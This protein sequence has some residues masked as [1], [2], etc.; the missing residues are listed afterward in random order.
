MA[1]FLDSGFKVF[2]LTP[3]GAHKAELKPASNS[4]AEIQERELDA[5][6]TEPTPI[7]LGAETFT[8]ELAVLGA[9]TSPTDSWNM[10]AIVPWPDVRESNSI[11]SFDSARQVV[12]SLKSLPEDMSSWLKLKIYPDRVL[13]VEMPLPDGQIGTIPID[14]GGGGVSIPPAQYQAWRAAHPEVK[15]AT[16]SYFTIGEGK[17]MDEYVLADEVHI[18]ALTV[19]NV[20][21]SP[22]TDYTRSLSENQIG[23]VGMD[24]LYYVDMIVD[25]KEGYAYF[26]PHRP[27]DP[28]VHLPLNWRVDDSV[29]VGMD[30]ILLGEAELKAVAHDYAGANADFARALALNPTNREAYFGRAEMER[31]MGEQTLAIADYTRAIDLNL[32]WIRTARPAMALR[33]RGVSRQIVGDFTGAVADYDMAIFKEPIDA[34]LVSI[35]RQLLQRR[36]GLPPEDFGKTVATWSDPWDKAMG[37]YASGDLSETAFLKTLAEAPDKSNPNQACEAYYLVGMMHLLNGDSAGARE[38]F[39][40]SMAAGPKEA[41]EYYM[42]QSEL[43]RLEPS[44]AK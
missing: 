26:R 15:P 13:V 1:I 4:A 37:Q 6:L 16:S 32:D 28:A 14:T 12:S 36:L 24:A 7:K 2:M 10:D 9:R 31:Q 38:F 41:D 20:G 33:G 17:V 8:A 3:R 43:A 27:T 40:K 22:A 34:H 18:G 5:W 29:K 42:A 39:H 19:F 11:L 25:N 44:T 30:S 23:F 35:Y 21:L